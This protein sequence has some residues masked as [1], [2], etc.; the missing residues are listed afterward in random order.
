MGTPI[1][2]GL[3]GMGA[4]ENKDEKENITGTAE[5]AM[6]NALKPKE[7]DPAETVRTSDTEARTVAQ[8]KNSRKKQYKKDKKAIKQTKRQALSE[9]DE[10]ASMFGQGSKE[11]RANKRAAMQDLRNKERGEIRADREARRI[12]K[13]GDK[14]NLTVAEATKAYETRKTTLSSY[15]K[16]AMSETAASVKANNDARAADNARKLAEQAKNDKPPLNVAGNLKG[17]ATDSDGISTFMKDY[18]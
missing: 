14:N 8:G 3:M 9:L 18:R 16:E 12:K 7:V 15:N 2:K 17:V 11:I 4:A 5:E 6:N 1:Y 13:Y 10:G